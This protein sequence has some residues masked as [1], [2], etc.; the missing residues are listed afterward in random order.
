MTQLRISPGSRPESTK[1]RSSS[2]TPGYIQVIRATQNFRTENDLKNEKVQ[3]FPLTVWKTEAQTADLP[4][5]PGVLIKT[6]ITPSGIIRVCVRIRICTCISATL[7]FS[8]W[9]AAA[10]Q[11]S[12]LDN[13]QLQTHIPVGSLL[14]ELE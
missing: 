4:K 7:P 11:T 2:H 5:V 9:P 13:P 6:P 8:T 1:T 12:A 3:P 14:L 10:C